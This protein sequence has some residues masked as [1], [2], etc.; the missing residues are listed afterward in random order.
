VKLLFDQNISFRVVNGLMN[1]FPEAKQV[2]DF[3]LEKASDKR[4]WIFAK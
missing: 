4:I 2:K 3:Q 1:I